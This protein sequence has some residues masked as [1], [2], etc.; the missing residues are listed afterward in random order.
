M[1]QMNN[2]NYEF[3]TISNNNN[4][5]WVHSFLASVESVLLFVQPL[6]VSSAT[7]SL[8]LIIIDVIIQKLEANVFLKKFNQLGGLQL[9]KD[10]RTLVS[11]F[12]VIQNNINNNVFKKSVRIP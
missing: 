3:N 10:V 6:F 12:N 9:D 4:T 7:E 2:T 11:A 8:F 5:L 1:D